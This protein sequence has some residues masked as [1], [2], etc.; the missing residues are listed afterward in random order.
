M[1]VFIR[2]LS[3][4]KI[5]NLTFP[6]KTTIPYTSRKKSNLLLKQN[7]E[8]KSILFRKLLFVDIDK[9]LNILINIVIFALLGFRLAEHIF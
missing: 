5:L 6:P 2:A 4:L 8:L 1:R 3:L 7:F 9:C